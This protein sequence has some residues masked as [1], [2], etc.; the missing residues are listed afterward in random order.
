VTRLLSVAAVLGL[1]AGFFLVGWAFG[2]DSLPEPERFGLR[3]LR[4]RL[5]LEAGGL[6]AAIEPAVRWA[7]PFAAVA[8]LGGLRPRIDRLLRVAGD[9]LGVTANEFVVLSLLGGAGGLL[10]GLAAMVALELAPV[11][12]VVFAAAGVLVPY[13][14]V[15]GVASARQKQIER[16]LPP[17][18]DLA[19]LCM[20]AGLDFTAT[21]R[22][23]VAKSER[24]EDPLREELAV[25][26]SQLQ[27]GMTRQRALALFAERVPTDGVR[28]FVRA[29]MQSEEKGT[30]LAEALKVQA[31]T[32]RTRRSVRG[33]EA[34]ARAAVLM[35][36]PLLLILCAILLVLMGP[37]VIR[38]ADGGF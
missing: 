7:A 33:E 18:I 15:T 8:P 34:A 32:L 11:L 37:F 5:A 21:L 28:T 36:V 24:A 25:I 31:V 4:R 35:M 27:L 20:G 22:Q 12:L 1:A 13:L 2:L 9:W 38:G 14:Q 26:L 17:A 19:A 6:F 29:I 3:G 23:L 16:A 30:P 10:A